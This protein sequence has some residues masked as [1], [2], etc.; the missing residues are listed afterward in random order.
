MTHLN[1]GTTN[2]PP[3]DHYKEA[4]GITLRCPDII[5]VKL[6]S[7]GHDAIVV[8]AEMCVVVPG[9]FYKKKLPQNLMEKTR[10]FATMR[11]EK[12]LEII[13]Q[14]LSRR[15]EQILQPPVSIFVI[16]VE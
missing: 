11:P 2:H 4:H 13:R 1:H 14:G 16:V 9:Q 7:A 15:D 6:G 8:P 10:D 3:Q 5:G 12:R